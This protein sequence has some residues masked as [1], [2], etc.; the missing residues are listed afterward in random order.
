MVLAQAVDNPAH[1]KLRDLA[2]RFFEWKG[3]SVRESVPVEG[4]HED[5]EFDFLISNKE[6]A[7]L[8]DRTPVGVLMKDWARVCGVNVIIRCETIM[9]D[10]RN[11]VPQG[12][13]VSNQFSV[14][15]R[16]LAQKANILLLSRGE[17]VSIF[18]IEPEILRNCYNSVVA[19]ESPKGG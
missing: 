9:N 5:Y 2:R 19:A 13:V 11:V 10:V 18:H 1:L 3:F 15:A 8:G 6:K 16:E 7:T 4:D 17:L 12:L 14:A